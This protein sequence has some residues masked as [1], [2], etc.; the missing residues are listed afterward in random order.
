[1]RNAILQLP[2]AAFGIW[3]KVSFDVNIRKPILGEG[4]TN[5]GGGSYS[6]S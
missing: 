2:V 4:S 6:G 5:G 3:K 1:M